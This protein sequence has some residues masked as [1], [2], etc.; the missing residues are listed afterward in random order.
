MSHYA[1]L[2]EL[3]IEHGFFPAGERVPFYSKLAHASQAIAAQYGLLIKPQPYGVSILADTHGVALP[4]ADDIRLQLLFFM[5]DGRFC[6]YTAHE[7]VSGRGYDYFV[8]Q[9]AAPLSQASR[10]SAHDGVAPPV[11]HQVRRPDWVVEVQLDK[12]LIA[13]LIAHYAAADTAQ[14]PSWQQARGIV[15]FQAPCRRWKYLFTA[16]YV[17][18]QCHIGDEDS[19][20][21]FE[22]WGTETVL[23][24]QSAQVFISRQPLWIQKISPY[25]FRLYQQGKILRN[26]LP[27]ATPFHSCRMTINNQQETLAE[28]I[29]ND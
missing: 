21:I 10:L 24:G 27:V 7:P 12:P 28:I 2:F 16:S 15:P 23:N 17:T 11:A 19:P 18:A 8:C 4:Q 5:P 29:V 20:D 6:C 1:T 3:H 14:Q 13:A 22:Y 25:R 9:R 26:T